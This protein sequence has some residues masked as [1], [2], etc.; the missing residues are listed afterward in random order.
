MGFKEEEEFLKHE[1]SK[2]KCRIEY[3]KKKEIIVLTM[4]EKLRDNRKYE[5]KTRK[6]RNRALGKI[7]GTMGRNSRTCRS[8]RKEVRLY[9]QDMRKTLRQKFIK[10]EKFVLDLN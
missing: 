2:F 5:G 8:L 1:H 6:L 7:E 9:C 4:K 10:K 3:K